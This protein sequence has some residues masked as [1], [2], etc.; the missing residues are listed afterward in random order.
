M[1][2][3]V[4]NNVRFTPAV[5]QMSVFP[6]LLLAT[7]LI[8]GVVASTELF[9]PGLLEGFTGAGP[10]KT[11]QASYWSMFAAPRADIGPEQEDATYIRDPRYFN[12]YAD[13]SRIGVAYDF[14]RLIA[15]KSDSKNLFFACALAGTENLDSAKFRTA[16][17]ADGF[18]VSLDDYMRDINGDG[19][20][21]Y[22]RILKW[23]DGSYQAICA[24]AEDTGFDSREVVDKDPPEDIARLLTFYEGCVMWLRFFGDMNDTVGNATVST[25]GRISIDE[26][27]RRDTTEGLQF[28]GIRQFLRLSDSSDLSL[29]FKVPIRSCRAWM[30]W[31]MFDEFTNNAKIFDFGNG[32]GKSNVFLGIYGK[33]DADTEGEDLRP[34]LCGAEESTV[35]EGRS[36]AQPVD[37]VSPQTLMKTTDANCNDYQ[38]GGFE[39][40]PRRL[41]PS[42]VGPLR[43]KKTGKAT[44]LYEVWDQQQR[45]LRLKVPAVF[46]KGVW[47]HV[48]VTATNNDAFRPNLAVYVN[49]KLVLEKENG[50]LPST[51]FLTNCYV[52]KSNWE[53]NVSQYENRDELFKGRLFD[54]RAY[55]V[56]VSPQ[57]IRD[58]YDWGREKLGLPLTS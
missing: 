24:R 42:V 51:G 44:L 2:G 32:S 54:F 7:L 45:K 16:S 40:Q 29:G 56:A 8:L 18:R 41:K 26:T 23:N 37:E 25:A 20:Q 38:C 57:L 28:D 53:N 31:V 15:P 12:D 35:P 47:T 52:G 55:S 21:D 1:Y 4:E 17:V 22:C 9:A 5:N 34:L 14:C 30:V 49:G 11:P 46:K 48:V 10:S 39:V 3:T 43:V 50:F 33:G 19:R 6:L 58:S 36:G 13:V 27:P